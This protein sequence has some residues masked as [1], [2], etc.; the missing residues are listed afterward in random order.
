MRRANI[1]ISMIL[2]AFAGY[3]AYLITGLPKRNIPH[4]LGPDFMPWILT[5]CLLLLSSLL[6]LKSLFSK[7][8][9]ERV[10]G[11]ALKEIAGILSLLAIIIAY[12]VAMVYF[13]YVFI[14][15]LFV[16]A[17]ML[18]SG[19]K[20]PKEIIFF[21]IGITLA[22]YLFFYRLFDVPL[23]GGRIF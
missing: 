19:S 16:A 15:P 12:I 1:F 10:I 2:F 5:V 17:M 21:P 8:K 9:G 6:L 13:G 20:K 14:T 11:I 23:P 22:V 18:I 7:G 3:Y 4:T